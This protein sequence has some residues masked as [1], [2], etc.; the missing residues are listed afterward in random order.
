MKF[1]IR[2][3]V[4]EIIEET[5]QQEITADEVRLLPMPDEIPAEKLKKFFKGCL[6]GSHVNRVE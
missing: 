3:F 6:W 2:D 4:C 5:Q 1:N